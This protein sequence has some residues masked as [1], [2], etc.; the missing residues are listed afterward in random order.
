MQS[1]VASIARVGGSTGFWYGRR[2]MKAPSSISLRAIGVFVS[3]VAMFALSV[4]ASPFSGEA[5]G[6]G[7][8]LARFSGLEISAT[9][10]GGI[11]WTGEAVLGDE[12]V[13][14]SAQ[15]TFS[16]VGLRG[17]VSMISEGWIGYSASRSTASGESIE[18]RGLLHLRWKSVIALKAGDS[19]VGSQYTVLLFGGRAQAFAGEFTGSA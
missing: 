10:S 5:L 15:G 3:G 11:E 16:G 6:T 13:R 4:L 1:V 2:T 17:I 8:I 18:I 7:K 12:V 9:L 14:F 19:V